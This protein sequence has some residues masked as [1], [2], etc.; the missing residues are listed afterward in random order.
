M[1]ALEFQLGKI[2]GTLLGVS[3][4]GPQDNFFELGGHSLLVAKMLAR[5]E[6]DFGQKLSMATIFQAPTVEKLA[7]P[8]FCLSRIA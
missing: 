4:V 8:L 1:D 6:R 5:L 2:W 7:T 3:R